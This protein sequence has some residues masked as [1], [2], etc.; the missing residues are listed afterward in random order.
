[1]V[2]YKHNGDHRYSAP[3]PL[4]TRLLRMIM[5][6]AAMF[7]VPRKWYKSNLLLLS[8]KFLIS[9]IDLAK[10]HRSTTT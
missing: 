3:R 4:R 2:T 5:K 7:V 9:S 8:C 10:I 6:I 1:M